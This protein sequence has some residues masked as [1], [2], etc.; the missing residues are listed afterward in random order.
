MAERVNKTLRFDQELIK[1]AEALAHADNRS[2]NNWIE[3]L[4]M[5]EVK[6]RKDEIELIS[7]PGRK[8]PDKSQN[9]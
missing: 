9:N 4:I 1:Q 3:T 5:H 6:N 7:L 8:E 2:L